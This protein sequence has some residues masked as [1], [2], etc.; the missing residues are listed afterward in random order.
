[1]L[2]LPGV[3]ARTFPDHIK[4]SSWMRAFAMGSSQQ[5]RDWMS[6]L[7]S[8]RKQSWMP[9]LRQLLFAMNVRHYSLR[10]A[11][12][13]NRL[14][15]WNPDGTRSPHCPHPGKKRWMP[16]SPWITTPQMVLPDNT[17]AHSSL[18]LCWSLKPPAESRVR[19]S[20]TPRGSSS[21][22]LL[23]KMRWKADKPA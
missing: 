18:I 5:R 3:H 8:H 12:T 23:L 11:S 19:K 10:P 17:P 14:R 21:I 13:S 9:C 7:N 20:F 4:Q 22:F 2:S 16:A 6:S 15:K 1:M